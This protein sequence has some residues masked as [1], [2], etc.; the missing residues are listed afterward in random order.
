MAKEFKMAAAVVEAAST[1]LGSI[2]LPRL[3]NNTVKMSKGYH[4]KPKGNMSADAFFVQTCRRHKKKN[5][6]V[7]GNFAEFSKKCS[8]RWKTMPGKEKSKF[9]ET[10]KADKV[11]WGWEVKDYGPAKGAKKRTLMPPKGRCLDSSYSVQNS[12]PRSNPQ[13]LASLSEMWQR[14]WARCGITLMTVKSSLTTIRQQ[15]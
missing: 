7:P 12:T 13:T 14:S 6:E 8:E 4:K 11:R 3:V 15:S 1:L 2:E 9:D 10:P 5:P